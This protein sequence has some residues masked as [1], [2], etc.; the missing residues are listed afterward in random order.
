MTRNTRPFCDDPRCPLRSDRAVDS[1][2]A[3]R[4]NLLLSGRPGRSTSPAGIR[5]FEL[6]LPV[7]RVLRY[8][9]GG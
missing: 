5:E 9:A 2:Q 7:R 3:S 4:R 1:R 6:A 8:L